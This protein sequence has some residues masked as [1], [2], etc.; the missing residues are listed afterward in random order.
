MN[1]NVLNAGVLNAGVLNLHQ[2]SAYPEISVRI[3]VWRLD[4]SQ[5]SRRDVITRQGPL[6]ALQSVGVPAKVTS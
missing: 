2:P 4:R 5:K 6:S 3:S 1:R